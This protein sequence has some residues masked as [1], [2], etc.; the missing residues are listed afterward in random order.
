[1]IQYFGFGHLKPASWLCEERF[2]GVVMDVGVS[3]YADI[4][5]L[6]TTNLMIVVACHL[7]KISNLLNR[8]TEPTNCRFI[9][10]WKHTWFGRKTKPMLTPNFFFWDEIKKKKIAIQIW[11]H[12]IFP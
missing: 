3:V 10:F 2:D 4:K 1:M 6:L 11:R 5:S 12:L 8:P 7:K 9:F